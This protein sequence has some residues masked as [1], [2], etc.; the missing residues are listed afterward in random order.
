MSIECI[1]AT[2]GGICIEA[3]QA[4]GQFWHLKSIVNNLSLKNFD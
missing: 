1:S 3:Y 4:E 2:V